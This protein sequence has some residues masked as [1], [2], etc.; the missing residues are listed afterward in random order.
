MMAEE[1]ER[2]IRERAYT[3]WQG[4]GRPEGRAMQHWVRAEAEIDQESNMSITDD[5]KKVY[6]P[7][8]KPN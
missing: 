3:I 6:L 8:R 7:P 2:L 1:R 4:E 5:G